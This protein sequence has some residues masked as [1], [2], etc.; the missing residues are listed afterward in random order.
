MR[1]HSRRIKRLFDVFHQANGVDAKL[2]Y[3]TILEMVS[4]P[5]SYRGQEPNLF[6][7]ANGMLSL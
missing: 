7:N 5:Y 6:A 1:G 4:V 2:V 3:K